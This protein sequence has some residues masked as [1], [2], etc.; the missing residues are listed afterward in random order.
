MNNENKNK[1]RIKPKKV[2]PGQVF[3]VSGLMAFEAPLL[4]MH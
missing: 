4:Y 1:V 2:W 3:T